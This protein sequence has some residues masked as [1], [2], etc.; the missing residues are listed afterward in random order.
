M[1][2]SHHYVAYLATFVHVMQMDSRVAGTSDIQVYMSDESGDPGRAYPALG[3]EPSTKRS[4]ALA[5]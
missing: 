1:L 5:I 2:V 4:G 3:R